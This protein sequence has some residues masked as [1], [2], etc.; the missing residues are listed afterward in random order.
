MKHTNRLMSFLLPI[1]L[2]KEID[3]S[4]AIEESRSKFIRE[5]IRK[6]LRRRKK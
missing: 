5:A 2:I 1:K 3:G 6:S 4:L